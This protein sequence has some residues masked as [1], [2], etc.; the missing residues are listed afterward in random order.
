MDPK[1]ELQ[2]YGV[3]SESVRSFS[4]EVTS[5]LVD[6][7]DLADPRKQDEMVP[8]GV[9]ESQGRPLLFYINHSRLLQPK[10]EREQKLSTMRRALG[11][12]G[13][14]AYLAVVK[15]G[16]LDVVP[17]SLSKRTPKWQEY[18]AG[19]GEAV[20]F[21]SR[22]AL[23]HYSGR[24][25]P[26]RTDS[27]F[28][29]MRRLLEQAA[30]R[31][32]D[33][34]H[35]LD[36]PDVLSLMGRALF[37]RFLID[38]QIVD[39]QDIGDIA[40]SAPDRFACFDT[41][42]DAA[43][44]SAWLDGTFNG[45]FLPLSDNGSLAF[46]EHV[47]RKT[48]NAVF[49]HLGAIMRGYEAIPGGYQPHLRIDWSDF[50]FAHVPVGLLSQ[51]YEA[52]CWKWDPAI[53]SSTSVHYTPRNIASMLVGEVFDSLPGASEC[54]VLDPACGG[55]VF[56]VLAFRKLYRARWEATGTRPDTRAIRKILNRQLTGFDISESAIRLAAL[57]LYLTAIELDPEPIP[58]Q[59]L[60]FDVLRD[61]VLFSFRRED[62]PENG[63]IIGALGEH[64]AKEFEGQFDVVLSNPP[65]TGLSKT[66]EE[67]RD[68][69]D[70]EI[71]K[72]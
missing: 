7:L 35:G 38:R 29:G 6:Y 9:A 42:Q 2:Q 1:A 17:V 26:A 19:S 63:P 39:E 11:C 21:F 43:K 67:K 13:Q 22:L 47:G 27:A 60:R 41:A 3:P 20:T 51:V 52:F 40:P 58:P 66:P 54:R 15:P 69:E 25:D 59:K 65:W 46:F 16:Q 44:T 55:A 10:S 33:P 8:D 4:G 62:D 53:A 14:R 34:R 50:D 64:V 12:R 24:G 30:T 72:E 23:G 45:D 68:G 57:S 5:D 28:Q 32:A 56:L 61:K 49:R 36:K 37:F 18:R 31:L 48:R 71:E 70:E